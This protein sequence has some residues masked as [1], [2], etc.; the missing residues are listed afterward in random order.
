MITTQQW[1]QKFYTGQLV[2]S[3]SSFMAY[4][5]T[6]I[7]KYSEFNFVYFL[8][9]FSGRT[10]YVIRVIHVQTRNRTLLKGMQGRVADL[11]FANKQSNL[12][13]CVDQA[14]SIFIW[15]LELENNEIK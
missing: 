11:G 3:N 1:E 2:A 9:F 4:S 6:G 7:F 12:F 10:G 14:G 13:A 8:S 15:N 5:L